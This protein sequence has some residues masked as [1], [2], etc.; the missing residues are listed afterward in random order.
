MASLGLGRRCRVSGG[1]AKTPTNPEEEP[2][3]LT[4]LGAQDT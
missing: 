2:G 3:S 4:Y 1:G